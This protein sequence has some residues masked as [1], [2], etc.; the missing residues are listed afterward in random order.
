M[1]PT[2]C[3]YE[4]FVGHK[5]AGHAWVSGMNLQRGTIKVLAK[6]FNSTQNCKIEYLEIVIDYGVKFK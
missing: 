2:S 4:N 5:Y 3:S 1:C 6:C